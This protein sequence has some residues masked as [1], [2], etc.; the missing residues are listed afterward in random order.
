MTMPNLTGIQLSNRIKE[1]RPDI[2]IVLCTGY[3]H[4]L[5]NRHPEELGLSAIVMKP[6]Q[7]GDLARTIR[8]VLDGAMSGAA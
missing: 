5:I 6:I 3:S 2:P 4:Q 8:M 1:I 7:T